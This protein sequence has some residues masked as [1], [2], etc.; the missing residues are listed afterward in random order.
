VLTFQTLYQTRLLPAAGDAF[1]GLGQHRRERAQHRAARAAFSRALALEPVNPSF[2]FSL[3]SLLQQPHSGGGSGAAASE[4]R[5]PD[6]L[7]RAE[8]LYRTALLIQPAFG[9]ASNNLGNLLRAA[10][11][12]EE[13][14]DFFTLAVRGAPASPS[15]VLNL[16]SCLVSLERYRD[17]A[18][19]FQTATVLLPSSA[20]AYRALGASLDKTGEN[21]AALRAF[22]RALRLEPAESNAYIGAA[23]ALKKRGNLKGALKVLRSCPPL[24]SPA[25]QAVVLLEIAAVLLDRAHVAL[26]EHTD[27][28]GTPD[29]DED[30]GAGPRHDGKGEHGAGGEAARTRASKVGK[31][32]RKHLD[33]IDEAEFLIRLAQNVTSTVTQDVTVSRMDVALED[34]TQRAHELRRQLHALSTDGASAARA[35]RSAGIKAR[36]E[37]TALVAAGLKLQ[38]QGQLPQARENFERAALLDPSDHEAHNALAIALLRSG[39]LARSAQHSRA[40]LRLSRYLC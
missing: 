11:N 5:A 17:A 22:K 7:R 15:Y 37:S 38:G 23:A 21:D 12:L 32:V 26:G 16:G 18:A 19:S 39:D 14:A 13:A 1:R 34:Q 29:P 2:M 35:D 6:D 8:R 33:D 27:S 30:D 25:D 40:A 20:R 28:H 36:E 31:R 9:D 24:E 3:A 10:G 4:G